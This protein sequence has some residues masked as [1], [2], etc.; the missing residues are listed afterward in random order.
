LLFNKKAQSQIGNGQKEEKKMKKGIKRTTFLL[1]LILV[2]ISSAGVWFYPTII[3]PKKNSASP[4]PKVVEMEFNHP[5]V[6]AEDELFEK[7]S[8]QKLES[9]GTIY[10]SSE[11]AA[12][13]TIFL[14]KEKG[15][16]FI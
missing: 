1:V 14:L 6:K 15:G 13:V 4:S 12:G 16:K 9:K 2:G 11:P 7:S 10:V 8:P 3:A 5:P